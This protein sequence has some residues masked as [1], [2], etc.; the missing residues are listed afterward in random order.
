M[1]HFPDK[2][3]NPAIAKSQN[4]LLSVQDDSESAKVAPA[5]KNN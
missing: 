1:F 4:P 3:Q 5:L 2:S